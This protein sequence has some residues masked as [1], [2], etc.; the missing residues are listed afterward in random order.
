VKV[1]KRVRIVQKVKGDDGIWRFASVKKSGTK[2]LWGNNSGTFFLEWWEGTK[3]RRESVGTTPSEA[4]EAHKRKTRELTGQLVEGKGWVVTPQAEGDQGT[5]IR[6]CVDAFLKHVEVHSPDKPKTVQRYRSVLDHF[7]RLLGRLRFVEAVQRKHI[8]EFKS[9]RASDKQGGRSGGQVTPATVN[10]E[11]SALRTFLNYLIREL[12]VKMENPC[13]RFKPIRDTSKDANRRPTTYTPEELERLFR[14]CDG[15]DRAAF[16]ALLLTGLREQELCYL[17]WDDVSLRKGREHIRIGPKPGF[18]PK[19]YEEREIPLPDDLKAIL[20][21]QPRESEW[22]FPGVKGGRGT[23]L[24]RRLKRVAKLAKVEDATLHK[25]RHTY[26]TRLL[27]SDADIVTVQRLLG[28][29]DLDTTKRYLN[30]D[31]DRKRSAVKKLNLAG[32]MKPAVEAEEP[33]EAA[34]LVQ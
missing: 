19:D 33:A 4:L 29:S 23:H 7:V 28:H 24:L 15:P 30:P 1:T 31:V 13:E 26:A 32:L 14:A 18:S 11:V 6:E 17:T 3:R 5:T 34:S 21:M 12:G 22:V 25:F 27:E 8:D 2:Y 20:E 16:S 10:F 9:A